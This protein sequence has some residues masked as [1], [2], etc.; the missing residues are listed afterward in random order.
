[1]KFSEVHVRD[2]ANKTPLSERRTANIPARELQGQ[3]VGCPLVL[4]PSLELAMFSAEDVSNHRPA[5]RKQRQAASGTNNSARRPSCIL[6]ISLPRVRRVVLPRP[7]GV[8]YGSSLARPPRMSLAWGYCSKIDRWPQCFECG[9]RRSTTWIDRLVVSRLAHRTV[10]HPSRLFA[11][12]RGKAVD[13]LVGF[14]AGHVLERLAQTVLQALD[15][16]LAPPLDGQRLQEVDLA[17]A[18]LA[19]PTP[20]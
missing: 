1:V 20:L 15:A 17:L 7:G 6:S 9:L 10:P 18:R 19:C 12:F 16:V 14:G 5:P 13:P 2:P 8:D 4:E 3:N 11:P